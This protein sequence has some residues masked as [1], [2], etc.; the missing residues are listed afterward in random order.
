MM[1]TFVKIQWYEMRS[2]NTAEN[3]HNL[4]FKR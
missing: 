4:E 3:S 1:K 2:Q